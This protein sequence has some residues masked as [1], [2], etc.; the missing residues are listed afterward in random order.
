MK[1]I[2]IMLMVGA[3]G[4]VVGAGLDLNYNNYTQAGVYPLASNPITVESNPPIG[5]APGTLIVTR[6][7]NGIYPTQV[8]QTAF[9][10]E[11]GTRTVIFSRN[12]NE[13][14]VWGNWVAAESGSN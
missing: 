13:S 7:N 14:L 8:E 5:L 2:L 3:I 6:P 12:R 4:T 10:T 9:Y 11:S 1:K